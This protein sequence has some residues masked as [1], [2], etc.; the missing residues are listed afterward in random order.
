MAVCFRISSCG[1]LL[2][3]SKQW[4]QAGWVPAVMGSTSAQKTANQMDRYWKKNRQLNRP[5]SPHLS[6]YKYDV[7]MVLSISNRITA[8]AVTIAFYLGPLVYLFGGKDFA[9]YYAMMQSWGPL[10]HTLIGTT[11]FSLAFC[12]SYHFCAS[13][14]HFIWDI[15]QGYAKLQVYQSGYA[16]LVVTLLMTAGL[17]YL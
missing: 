1:K 10:G 13:I 16:M 9:G 11:K 14:R 3:G 7:P 8:S 17:M 2:A 5:L 6:I 12:F 4:M 15:G